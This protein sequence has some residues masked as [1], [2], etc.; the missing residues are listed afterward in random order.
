MTKR[1]EV[2]QALF[3]VLSG[4]GI[5]CRRNDPKTEHIPASGVMV[6]HDG[7][8]G[9]PEATMSP[10]MW[11]FIHSAQIDMFA[12][13]ENRDTVFDGMCEAVAGAIA[14]DRTLGGVCDL[15]LP[16]APVQSQVDDYGAVP[17]KAASVQVSLYY[18]T[19]DPLG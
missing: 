17:V 7:D 19:T 8:P 14:A 12:A 15:C 3:A 9:E 2:L 1:E 16:D 11:H 18:A 13:G 6:L 10:A 4:T 5:S